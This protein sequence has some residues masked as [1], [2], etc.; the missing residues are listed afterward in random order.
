MTTCTLLTVGTMMIM[1][2]GDL[3]V[4]SQAAP[5]GAGFT[6]E[7]VIANTPINTGSDPEQFGTGVLGFGSVTM[8]GAPKTPTWTRVAAE[9]RFPDL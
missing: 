2:A 4:G 8:H 5:I 1:P 3:E 7:L 9:P 6:A